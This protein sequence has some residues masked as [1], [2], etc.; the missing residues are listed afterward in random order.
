MT[1]A[2]K[3]GLT[4]LAIALLTPPSP[5]LAQDPGGGKAARLTD[6]QIAAIVVAANT[7]DIEYGKLAR[8]R[9]RNADVRSFAEAMIASHTAVNSQAAALATRLRLTPEETE[10]SRGLAL[11]AEA[12]RSELGDLSGTAF[13][14]AYIENEIAFH[15]AV[16]EAIDK[17]LRPSAEHPELIALIEVVR[18]AI[19]AHL[20]HARQVRGR[21]G[22]RAHP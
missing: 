2:R 19:V 9:T 15:E 5:S 6:A 3:I 14:R 16:L 8:A 18:P 17:A 10:T 12:K 20:E 13:D 1:P 4:A 11:A 22:G 7:I 21:L